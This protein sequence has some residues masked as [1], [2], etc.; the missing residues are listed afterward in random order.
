MWKE[1][2]EVVVVFKSSTKYMQSQEQQ[3]TEIPQES[4]QEEPSL[5][6]EQQDS[7]LEQLAQIYHQVWC[8]DLNQRQ[9]V[10]QYLVDELIFSQLQHEAAVDLAQFR[11]DIEEEVWAPEAVSWAHE[12]VSWYSRI[13]C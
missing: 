13:V 11:L 3:K 4:V 5:T 6:A 10:E 12:V 8:T 7:I 2:R 9:E 1:S